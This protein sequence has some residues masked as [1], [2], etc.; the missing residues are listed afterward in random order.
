M[1]TRKGIR[2]VKT[3]GPLSA[4]ATCAAL[5]LAGVGSSYA[6]TISGTVTYSGSAPK[7]KAISMDADPVCA[8]KHT[9]PVLPEVLVLG[10]DNAMGNIFVSV[11]SGVPDKKYPGPKDPVTINQLGCVYVPHVVGVMAEQPL[12]ILNSDGILHN[13]HGLPK[14]NPEY[15]TAMPK[16]RKEVTRTFNTP[17]P[18]FPMKCDVHPWMQ[19]YIA[20]MS[21]PYFDVTETDGKFSIS[22]L[23]AGTF[24][25]EA[26]HEKLGAQSQKV[27][28]GAGETKQIQ[29]TFKAPSK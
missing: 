3:F 23:P 26:W 4:L 16:F 6:G 9:S 17:E 24:D 2:P 21:H 14:K 10:K 18:L 29:F 11:K 22:D 5:L 19:A 1:N 15:N 28:I 13:I 12:Q 27:T 8:S 7:L 25:I 20:V